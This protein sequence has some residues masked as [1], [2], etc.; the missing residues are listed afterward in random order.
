MNFF[1]TNDI[2]GIV[3]HRQATFAAYFVTFP[4]GNFGVYQYQVTVIARFFPSGNIYNHHSLKP[5]NLWCRNTDRAW[6]CK[7]GFFK[8]IDP[9]LQPGIKDS[10]R[11]R[12]LTQPFIRVSE[13]LQNCHAS[14]DVGIDG[15]YID[16][17]ALCLQGRQCRFDCIH[18]LCRNALNL[19]N[20][21]RFGQ[22][23]GNIGFK[24]KDI[25]PGRCG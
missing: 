16:L 20:I 11:F 22:G 24:I 14:P 6:P 13:N 18:T 19:Q 3:R 2:P 9:G 12:H 21:D 8:I 15:L 7:P 25:Q 5:A 1:S 10:N 4:P 23:T 17:D